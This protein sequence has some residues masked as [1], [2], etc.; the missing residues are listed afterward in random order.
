MA[1]WP[2]F[3]S[4]S[5]AIYSII[6][7]LTSMT[8]SLCFQVLGPAVHHLSHKCSVLEPADEL[9]I[10]SITATGQTT[11]N[12]AYFSDSIKLHCLVLCGHGLTFCIFSWRPANFIRWRQ[13]NVNSIVEVLVAIVCFKPVQNERKTLYDITK[14]AML[15]QRVPT[16]S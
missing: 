16:C 9:F 13:L 4:A 1:P 6:Q 10:T 7:D 12:W 2:P 8:I 14:A 11:L 3:G 15:K 5:A